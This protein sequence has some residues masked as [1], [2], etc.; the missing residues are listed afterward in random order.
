MKTPTIKETASLLKHLKGYIHDDSRA[1]D[2][3]EDDTPSMVVTIACNN[4]GEWDY[5]TG[6]NSYS[7]AAY[8]YPHWAVVYLFR[9]SNCRDL[10]RQAVSDLKDL[11][12]S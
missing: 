1:F 7:G 12:V 5:Q 6:D 3:S 9:N 11:M 4:D 10:A 8:S 2:D